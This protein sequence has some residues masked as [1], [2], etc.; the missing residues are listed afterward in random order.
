MS[1]DALFGSNRG[2]VW[3]KERS[4]FKRVSLCL[5]DTETVSS[6]TEALFGQTDMVYCFWWEHKDRLLNVSN[7]Y[8]FPQT[9]FPF[10][11]RMTKPS[12]QHRRL[13]N[14]TPPA[15]KDI[16]L[17]IPFQLQL[18]EMLASEATFHPALSST[19][20]HFCQSVMLGT[21]KNTVFGS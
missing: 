15:N 18:T 6:N 11:D 2:S 19:G 21:E 4:F 3:W 5:E 17:I 16:F 7:R 14:A 8:L 12:F 1:A 10:L 9:P 13:S 20:T